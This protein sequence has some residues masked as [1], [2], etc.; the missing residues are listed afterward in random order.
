MLVLILISKSFKQMSA[1]KE[2]E[3]ERLNWSPDFE[4]ELRAWTK[5]MKIIFTITEWW[6]NK[7]WLC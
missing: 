1:V 5:N 6:L 7:N 3:I 4:H 2:P